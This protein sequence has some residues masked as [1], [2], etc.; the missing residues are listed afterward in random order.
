MVGLPSLINRFNIARQIPVFSKLSW[1][2]IRKIARHAVIEDHKKG[3]IIRRQGDPPDA[4]YCLIA[5]RVQAYT[6]GP[7]GQKENIEYIQRGM[8]FGIISLLTGQSHSLNF[9]VINDCS[10]FKIPKS[11]FHA[12]LKSIPHLAIEFSQSLSQ[13]VREN[14]MQS[15]I[16]QASTIISIYSPAK[17]SGSSTYAV[18][19]ALSLQRESGKKVIFVSINPDVKRGSSV[20]SEVGEASPQWKRKP[21]HLKD[22]ISA[23][24]RV[25]EHIIKGQL[26]ID[27]L[28]A[29]FDP[30]D[31]NLTREISHFVS[32]LTDDYHFVVVDLPNEMD[33]VVLQT[34]VQSDLIQLVIL[35][36]EED[37][38]LAR[39]VIK[40]LRDNL[41]ES[42]RAENIQVIISGI[43]YKLYLS[44]DEINKAIEYSVY[45]K[46]PHINR[47]DLTETVVSPA[48]TVV[49]PD[50]QSEYAKAITRIARRVSGVLVGLVLGGGAALGIAHI[51]VIRVLEQENIPVDIV[52]GSS[53]GALLASFW[54][55]GKNSTE[56]EQLAREFTTKKDLFKLIDPPVNVAGLV[57]GHGI[58]RWLKSRLGD[59]TFYDT[60]RPLKVVAYDLIHRE[61]L[62]IDQGSLVEAVRRSIS[63]PG[64]IPPVQENGRVIIDGGVL[65]P[66]PTNVLIS[67]GIKK[68]I[69][70]NVLQSPEAASKGHDMELKKTE[71][72]RKIPFWKSPFHYL[73][74]RLGKA[75]SPNVADIIVRTLQATEYV[76]AKQSA[77]RA[78]ILIEPD[79]TGINW[80]ELY[81]VD[82]LIQRGE[83]ATRRLLPAIKNLVKA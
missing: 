63:I 75:F 13:R 79:L 41:K 12:I 25:K 17:G 9:E 55:I 11:E 47:E 34:L 62:I 46:L 36:R 32:V 20:P 7:S 14:V 65:N 54:A 40:H 64:V 81:R 6:L 22:F 2:E 1:L 56:L 51:G 67:Y 39:H 8:Y 82:E 24:V 26:N 29:V 52:A 10:V 77:Q 21:I 57:G 38:R 44:F 68:I 53:M 4:F 48:I 50:P 45:T 16:H 31:S 66:L 74:L 18:N 73:G 37:L 59:K 70:I 42:F 83:E 35:D 28:N 3:D 19:L 49:V 61:E 27:L 72:E 33:D 15:K 69:A 76:I 80:F 58:R 23:Y 71:K 30:N 5:G 60:V 78:S 43:Q